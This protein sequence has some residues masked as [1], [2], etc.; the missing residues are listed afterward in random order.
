[1]RI[2]SAIAAIAT[3]AIA[4]CCVGSPNAASAAQPAQ[5][6]TSQQLFE[7]VFFGEGP[8]GA[9]LPEVW[10][11]DTRAYFKIQNVAGTA[12]FDAQIKSL[13]Q[14]VANVDGTY[15]SAIGQELTSGDPGR[16]DAAM[17]RTKADLTIVARQAK[18]A[19]GKNQVAI[20]PMVYPE[21]VNTSVN[22]NYTYTAFAAVLAI[23]FVVAAIFVV[24]VSI[25]ARGNAE[26]AFMHDYS[27]ALIASRL[28]GR[29]ARSAR[30]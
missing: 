29:G 22:V 17:A 6:F 25:P 12:G 5:N 28:S 11:A 30:V 26:T 14:K 3:L 4:F 1:M 8:A 7:G 24:V 10:N 23:A 15:F 9:L 13:E 20:T 2:K 21:T 16:V 27:T 18:I 19:P